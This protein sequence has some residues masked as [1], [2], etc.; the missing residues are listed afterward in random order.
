MSG[1]DYYSC[2][3]CWCKTFYDAD[4]NYE[5]D[6]DFNYVL[7]RVGEMKVICKECAKTKTVKIIDRTPPKEK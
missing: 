7:P 4:L 6:G 1:A 2:D 3:V 5:E